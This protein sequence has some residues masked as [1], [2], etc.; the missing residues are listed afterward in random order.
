MVGVHV[1]VLVV[2][3]RALLVVGV[4]VVVL[5]STLVEGKVVGEECEG[6]LAV[7]V[8]PVGANEVLLVEDGVIRAEEVE[9]LELQLGDLDADVEEL[10]GSFNVGIVAAGD[11]VLAGEARLGQPVR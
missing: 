1:C 7:D 3:V 6:L 9:V 8:E 2:V 11:L 10:T 5:G 4:V